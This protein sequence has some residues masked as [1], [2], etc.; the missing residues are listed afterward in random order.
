M[1]RL[2]PEVPANQ[3]PDLSRRKFLARTSAGGMAFGT[4]WSGMATS[5]LRAEDSPVDA[6][7]KVIAGFE[8]NEPAAESDRIVETRL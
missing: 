8:T 4:A 6:S 7:G 5:L 3:F 1:L 2:N